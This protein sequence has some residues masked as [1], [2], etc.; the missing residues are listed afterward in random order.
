MLRFRPQS[1]DVLGFDF[2]RT[3]ERAF[4]GYYSEFGAAPTSESGAS[5]R[6]A[7]RRRRRRRRSRAPRADP[8]DSPHHDGAWELRFFRD[9]LLPLHKDALRID[10]HLE[11]VL[12]EDRPGAISNGSCALASPQMVVLPATTG[13]LEVRIIT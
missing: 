12:A 2:Y 1:L 13:G 4:E 7:S 8:G 11:R 6:K 9:C 10:D 5:A 3:A